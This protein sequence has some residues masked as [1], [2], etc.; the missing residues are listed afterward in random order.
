M[1]LSDIDGVAQFKFRVETNEE[2]DIE[3]C[4]NTK[5]RN[6]GENLLYSVSEDRSELLCNWFGKLRQSERFIPFSPDREDIVER[7]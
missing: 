5:H 2:C 1:S 6:E 4:Q 3:Y 7:E